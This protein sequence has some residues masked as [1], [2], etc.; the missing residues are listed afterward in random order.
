[1]ITAATLKIFINYSQ[2]IAILNSLNLNWES[3]ISQMFNIHQAASGGLQQ[4]VALECFF[5]GKIIDIF[6]L[7]FLK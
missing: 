5:T 2:T 7:L 6:Y 4:V 1:M 3:K